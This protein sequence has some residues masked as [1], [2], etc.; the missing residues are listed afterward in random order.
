MAQAE[1]FFEDR[2]FVFPYTIFLFCDLYSS[3]RSLLQKI[4]FILK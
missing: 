3:E 2:Q 1:T 4:T